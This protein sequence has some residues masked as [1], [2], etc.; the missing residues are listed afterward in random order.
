MPYCVRIRGTIRVLLRTQAAA[1]AI[2]AQAAAGPELFF[3]RTRHGAG[4]TPRLR[5][6]KTPRENPTPRRDLPSMTDHRV[7][8]LITDLRSRLWASSHGSFSAWAQACWPAW[9]PA[10][11]HRVSS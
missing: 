4:K 11:D 8:H 9:S 1:P 7:R 10:E 2:F 5:T 6:V 3:A